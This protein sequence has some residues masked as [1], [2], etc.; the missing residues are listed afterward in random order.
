MAVSPGDEITALPGPASYI[1]SIDWVM[2]EKES[3]PG[4]GPESVK[5]PAVRTPTVPG[6]LTPVPQG[7]STVH[8]GH[9]RPHGAAANACAPFTAHLQGLLC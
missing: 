1:H 8:A 7:F 4:D 3:P 5:M 2:G 9:W 6:D